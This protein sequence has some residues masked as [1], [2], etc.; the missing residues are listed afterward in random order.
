MKKSN[1]VRGYLYAIVSAVIFGLM[2]LMAKSIYAGGVTPVT[3]VFLRNALSLPILAI[4]AYSEKKTFAVPVK[5]LPSL[6]MISVMG[7]CLTPLL[8]FSSY[9]FISSGMA[10]VFHFIYPAAVVLANLFIFC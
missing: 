7:C 9:R 8:L 5:A 4:L 6:G 2:P 10:T 3:L 1:A